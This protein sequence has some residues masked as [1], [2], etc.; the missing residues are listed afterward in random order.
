[1]PRRARVAAACSPGWSPS[2]YPQRAAGAGG[3]S[4]LPPPLDADG[5]SAAPQAAAS[6]SHA[7]TPSPLSDRSSSDTEVTMK[8]Q[9]GQCLGTH[10]AHLPCLI[11]LA[12]LG[13]TYF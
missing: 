2:A 11:P 12:D 9:M 3:P 4:G 6:G 10:S 13:V 8:V 5:S 7:S 1:M